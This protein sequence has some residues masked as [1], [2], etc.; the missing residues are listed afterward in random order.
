MFLNIQALRAHLEFNTESPQQ[1]LLAHPMY[2]AHDPALT[3]NDIAPLARRLHAA[4]AT[5]YALRSTVAMA[6][7]QYLC[8]ALHWTLTQA[9][10]AV[11]GTLQAYMYTLGVTSTRHELLL[12]EAGRLVV[13]NAYP[14]AA[15]FYAAG[16]YGDFSVHRLPLSVYTVHPADPTYPEVD[17]QHSLTGQLRLCR[18]LLAQK[19]RADVQANPNTALRNQ[20]T[21]KPI[22]KWRAVNWQAITWRLGYTTIFD[23]L[24][25]LRDGDAST[26][27][28]TLAA[29][30]GARVTAF[31]HDLLAVIHWLNGV[32]EAY[33]AKAIGGAAYA[34]MVA[35]M[36]AHLHEG[37]VHER[38]R[39]LVRAQECETSQP[40]LF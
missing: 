4:W 13:K 30:S 33:V 25:P 40:T 5:E 6:D 9:Y 32:H 10:F 2:R 28:P 1:Q 14:R 11:F 27:M 17:A 38:M 35:E 16:V 20:Q 3:A 12:R 31:H 39:A 8:D 24:A 34:Q 37:F 18:K 26:I 23:L 7:E 29:R 22:D 21:G 36:P 19:V 15:S